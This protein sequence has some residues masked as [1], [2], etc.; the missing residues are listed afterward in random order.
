MPADLFLIVSFHNCQI[1][2]LAAIDFDLFSRLFV[3]IHWLLLFKENQIEEEEED[4]KRFRKQ[5]LLFSFFYEPGR[6][7]VLTTDTPCSTKSSSQFFS[8]GLIR[9]LLSSFDQTIR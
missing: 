6:S 5:L 8:I 9:F 7:N 4:G 3:S 2:L 1:A